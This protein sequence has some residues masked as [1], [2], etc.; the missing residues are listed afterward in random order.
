MKQH[1][2]TL[3]ESDGHVA[4]SID[5][6][7]LFDFVEDHLTSHGFIY[8]YFR[9]EASGDHTLFVMHFGV[10]VDRARLKEVI[11]LID[12]QEIQRVWA[13]NN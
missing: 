13:I 12:P 6:R 10:G 2:V 4:I 7:E 3:D 1:H 11:G 5:D 9:E 8:D